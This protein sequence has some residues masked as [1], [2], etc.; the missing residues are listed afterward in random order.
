VQ[1]SQ[2]SA[3]TNTINVL[4]QATVR[5]THSLL[6]G[7]PAINSSGTT[8]KCSAITDENYDFFANTCP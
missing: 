6:S 4:F 5:V 3:S 1:N 7:G 8:L 2:I